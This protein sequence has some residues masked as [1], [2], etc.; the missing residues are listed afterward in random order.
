MWH[1]LPKAFARGRAVL[2]L[3]ARLFDR[4]HI[5]ESRGLLEQEEEMEMNREHAKKGW[6]IVSACALLAILISLLPVY[7]ANKDVYAMDK[8]T[9][10][11]FLQGDS[12]W[13]E[14]TIPGAGKMKTYGCA[15]SCCAM[16]AKYY[17]CQTDPGV[18]FDYL[19][20][21][22]G[23]TSV[24]NLDWQTAVNSTGGKLS[25][26]S[27]LKYPDKAADLGVINSYLDSGIPVILEVRYKRDDS[28][29]FSHFVV[30]TGHDGTST[31][32][33]N[34]PMSGRTT[35]DKYCFWSGGAARAI[36]GH[37]VLFGSG[38]GGSTTPIAPTTPTVPTTPSIPDTGSGKYQ[39]KYYSN[40][41]LSGS[42]VLS[43]S[44][45][46]INFN[47]GTGGPGSPCGSDYFSCEIVGTEYFSNSG[48]YDFSW[49]ADDKIKL[50]I[51]GNCLVD[52][53]SAQNGAGHVICQ[54]SQG[55][56]I[57]K[58]Q[59]AE[60]SGDALLNVSW[61]QT[62]APAPT[63][64]PTP[65]PIPTSAPIP[66]PVVP[67]PTAVPTSTP[68]GR[69]MTEQ[70]EIDTITKSYELCF[71]Q[72]PSQSQITEWRNNK[73]WLTL[74]DLER[75]H[76]IYIQKHTIAGFDENAAR[77]Q[78]TSLFER[79]LGYSPDDT[80]IGWNVMQMR[81]GY[82]TISDIEGRIRAGMPTVTPPASGSTPGDSSAGLTA[83]QRRAMIIASYEQVLYR[84]PSDVEIENWLNDTWWDSEDQLVACHRKY[85]E[86]NTIANFDEAGTRQAIIDAFV[87]YLGYAPSDYDLNYNLVACRIGYLN[88][89][90]IIEIL[91]Q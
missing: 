87:K 40:D 83:D 63:K 70:Q 55:N 19:L 11:L 35:L 90:R 10:P 23:F 88:L 85:I 2:W 82:M 89:D 78:F 45:D 12:P 64:A 49:R 75:E 37:C 47:W 36:F 39:I 9:F 48:Y 30:C 54:L 43:G 26:Y 14:K 61:S 15:V 69:N 27:R 31:Y 16:I 58:V 57:I 34:D 73:Y 42:S 59:Y 77:E 18:M 29:K 13:G 6:K 79:M 84:E 80:Q 44:S 72:K 3:I 86:E 28:S 4:I 7:F 41:N 67:A 65:T 38:T 5:E 51:D 60:M 22:N 46:S 76:N 20:Q 8:N 62:S 17:G 68:T 53:W 25:S 66:S 24:G 50:Y 21:K 81:L 71:Y 32:Y 52:V 1:A 33:I 74:E 91:Q 56:H